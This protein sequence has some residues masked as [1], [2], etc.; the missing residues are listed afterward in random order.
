MLL[1]VQDLSVEI[2]RTQI[3]NKASFTLQAGE[4]VALL[5]PNGAGKSTLVQAI[6]GI[7]KPSG[8][9][10]HLDVGGIGGLAYLPQDGIGR[11]GLTV[12]EAIL[13]GRY[14]QL[15]LTVSSAEI[16]QARDALARFGI[17]HLA[18]RT[19][20][21]LS[22]GQRQLAGLAQV[23]FRQPRVMLLDEP[24]SAL[25]LYR[26]LIVLDELQR[27]AAERKIGVLAILHDLSLATR[28]ADRILFLK[29]GALVADDRTEAVMTSPML[30]QIYNIDAEIL[31][32][33]TDAI[34]V[35]AL[36]AI[37]PHHEEGR[38]QPEPSDDICS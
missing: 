27:I 23:F 30:R 22:G 6:A 28:F 37:G 5:G 2:G 32:T 29:D 13:L 31:R 36:A 20:E 9:A 26:Q 38:T 14:D 11:T 7:Q 19:V 18:S 4:T 10:V 33:R 24:T 17:D 35:A 3:I 15:G 21:S 25:D 12:V 1:S 8:G 16:R 34:Q